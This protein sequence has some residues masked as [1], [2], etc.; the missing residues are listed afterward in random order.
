M[1]NYLLQEEKI[2]RIVLA[3]ARHSQVINETNKNIIQSKKYNQKIQDKGL[4]IP[5]D[6]KMSFQH[7]PIKLKNLPLKMVM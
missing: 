1:E 3:V 6:L 5:S 4:S 2:I 7:L